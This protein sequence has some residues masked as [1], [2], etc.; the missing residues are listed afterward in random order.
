MKLQLY[1]YCAVWHVEGAAGTEFELPD[2]RVE[3]FAPTAF[4]RTLA[5][6]H[7]VRCDLLHN[8]ELRLAYVSDGTARLWADAVGLRYE[9]DLLGEHARV[10][11]ELVASG[12]I[13]GAS[14]SFF[15]CESREFTEGGR[16]VLE[17]TEVHLVAFALTG[18][19]AYRATSAAIR[20]GA[21]FEPEV[22][23]QL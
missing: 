17:H 13:R 2:G 11:R 1:G 5:R 6:G 3:R 19:P 8:S 22:G 15:G 7:D 4:D 21:P 9:I 20:G 10:A 16:R 14:S 12:H 23:E 18:C